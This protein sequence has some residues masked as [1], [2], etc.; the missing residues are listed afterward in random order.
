MTVVIGVDRVAVGS[1]MAPRPAPD[2]TAVTAPAAA[3]PTDAT[4]HLIR[5]PNGTSLELFSS[6]FGCGGRAAANS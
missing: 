6:W 4:P 3:S 2:A 5:V 1:V